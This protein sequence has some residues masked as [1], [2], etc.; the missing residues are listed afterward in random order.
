MSQ[1]SQ[2]ARRTP[3]PL[4][5]REDPSQ[6]Q[7]QENYVELL[8]MESPKRKVSLGADQSPRGYLVMTAIT[9]R[10]D[11]NDAVALG[12]SRSSV[13]SND[14]LSSM[15][16]RSRQH[17]FACQFD[18]SV[19]NGR[20]LVL[21]FDASGVGTFEEMTRAS[22]LRLTHDAAMFRTP[23]TA[24]VDESISAMNSEHGTVVGPAG[25]KTS[26]RRLSFRRLKPDSNGIKATAQQPHATICDVQVRGGCPFF[27]LCV[28]ES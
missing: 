15:S 26:S 14:S 18:P 16:S 25:F 27:R 9:D 8:V 20:A 1:P 21:K 5:G 23:A 19:K 7:Q 24:E 6:Q 3:A 4:D 2:G 17:K 12:R 10:D 11:D 13:E 22:L 28:R